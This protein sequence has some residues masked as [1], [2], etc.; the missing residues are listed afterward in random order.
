MKKIILVILACALASAT[1]AQSIPRAG[2]VGL[3][4]GN[5]TAQDSAGKHDGALPYGMNYAPGLSG[6]AFDFDGVSRE[7]VS[8]PDSP[9]FGLTRTLTVEGW[10]YPRQYG[11]YIFFYG[12]DRSGLDPYKIDLTSDGCIRFQI[13]D[14]K[15]QTV[16]VKAPIQLD[17]WQHV[18]AIFGPR[19]RMRLFVNGQLVAST[20]T[21]L[22]PLGKLDP[23]QNPAIGI[24]NVSG[25]VYQ[26]PFNGLIGDIALYSRALTPRQILSIYNDGAALARNSREM[27]PAPDG[28]TVSKVNYYGSLSSDEARFT[29]D[30][31]AV[32][33]NKGESSAPLL[34]GDV[35]V[36]CRARL[37]DASE[38]SS[39]TGLATR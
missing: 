37:P 11:G 2:L 29:L 30:I 21:T 4:R 7:R 25:T 36:R 17:Q 34:E 32:A 31:N 20:T 38:N 9:A 6:L 16:G 3:W 28:L 19:G 35:A 33:A 22:K 26:N 39:A 15:N 23:G 18:A 13:T 8:V 12:D 27:I 24:G 14:D 5:G 10:I 1:L